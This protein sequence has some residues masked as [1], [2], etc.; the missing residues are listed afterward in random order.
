MIWQESASTPIGERKIFERGNN[1][2]LYQK[3]KDG[4]VE[5]SREKV[6]KEA[7]K[8]EQAHRKTDDS[9]RAIVGKIEPDVGGDKEHNSLH[10]VAGSNAGYS[11]QNE[12]EGL[13]A[14]TERNNGYL[15]SGDNGIPAVTDSEIKTADRCSRF[16]R[17]C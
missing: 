3:T 6:E 9:I 15:L 4:C 14:D 17:E 10:Q 16:T 1:F 7:Q 5:L 2:V 11:G 8:Y 13:Q 12:R